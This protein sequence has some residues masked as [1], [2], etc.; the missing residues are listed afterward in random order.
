M[1]RY[2]SNKVSLHDVYHV[3]G[4]KKN[5]LSVAQLTLSGHYAL[6]RPRDVNVYR[7]LKISKKSTMEGRRLEFVYVMLAESAYGD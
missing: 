6:F 3:S 5:L 7:N 2:N 1:P 4:V